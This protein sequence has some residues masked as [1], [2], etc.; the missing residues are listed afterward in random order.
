M[1]NPKTQSIYN[2]LE[3]SSN[4]NDNQCQFFFKDSD[5]SKVEEILSV[6]K[7]KIL[8]ESNKSKETNNTGETDD[9]NKLRELKALLDD[10]IITQKDFERKK[11][12]ILGLK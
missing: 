2:Y 9:F 10:G 6:I 5:K 3:F 8:N 4:S 7:K 12:Q 1:I 11:K